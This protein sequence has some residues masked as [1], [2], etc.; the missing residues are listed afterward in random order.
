MKLLI[1]TQRRDWQLAEIS[2]FLL[3]FLRFWWLLQFDEEGKPT[4][5]AEEKE[6]AKGAKK[7]ADK[8]WQTATKNYETYS[9]KLQEDPEFLNKLRAEREELQK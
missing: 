7:K 3:F 5:G 4:H 2:S 6:L 1:F 9:K 8:L